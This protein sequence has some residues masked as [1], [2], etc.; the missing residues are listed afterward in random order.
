MR[1]PPRRMSSSPFGTRLQDF[2]TGSRSLFRNPERVIIGLNVQP[3]DAG[4]HGALP[5]VADARAGL[6]ALSSALS[7]GQ[8]REDWTIEA[9][10]EQARWMAQAA[11][12]TATT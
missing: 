11:P 5:L 2:T 6:S 10:E 7:A 4:K 3:F 12:Y 8:H 1:W 9:R